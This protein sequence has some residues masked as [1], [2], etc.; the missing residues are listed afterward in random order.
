MRKWI[1]K[2]TVAVLSVLLA[3]IAAAQ[4]LERSAAPAG[5][6]VYFIAPANG[7]VVSSPLNV[8]FGLRNMGVAPAGVNMD[9][10]GHH[11]LLIDLD[12]LPAMDAPLP[13][14]G[15]VVHFGLG[16]TETT[17]ELAPGVHRL[18]L[19]LGNFLHVPHQPAVL[20]EE[21]TITVR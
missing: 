15:Q 17:L 18:Q 7:A 9:A 5:A 10:T 12:K 21:I 1:G 6:E 4:S 19:L 8:K 3:Q 13:A 20:S 2:T 16:Q 11:H 14:T